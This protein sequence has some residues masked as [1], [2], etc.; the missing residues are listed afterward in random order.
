M[1]VS[2]AIPYMCVVTVAHS[3]A[4]SP[5]DE[6]LYV[7]ALL[8]LPTQGIVHEGEL[9]GDETLRM[10]SCYGVSPFGTFG[11]PCGS[12][13]SHRDYPNQGL[14]TAANNVPIYFAIT[15]GLGDALHLVSGVDY[16]TAWRLTGSAWLIGALMVLYGLIRSWRLSHLSVLA[17]GLAF[18]ASPFSWWT[19]SY[20]ST[21]APAF[22]FGALLLWL[23][24]RARTSSGSRW[25]LFSLSIVAI[26]FKITNVIGVVFALLYTLIDSVVHLRQGDSIISRARDRR[27]GLQALA[28]PAFGLAV[29]ITLQAAW[30]VVVQLWAVGSD[31]ADQ[32]ISIPLSGNEFLLQFTNFLPGTITSSPIGAYVPTFAY[33]PLSWLT[34]AGVITALF[35]IRR[36]DPHRSITLAI[37]VA[38]ICAAPGLAL[39]L[40]VLNGSYF[41]LPPRYGATLLPGFL[42]AT[43]FV[44]KSRSAAFAVVSYA[45]ALLI[46]GIWLSYYLT[47]LG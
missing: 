22:M 32:G 41:Q 28:A 5:I 46:V 21:D 12:Q 47:S 20:I 34:V 14:S 26:I 35:A 4:L 44:L 43:A 10:M 29:G 18:V 27:A 23:A 33:A 7:D 42:L 9:V 24:S 1:L 2:I 19:Y 31:R 30:L 6:W 37:A 39:A 25:W 11:S 16:L 3:R 8:K 38:S 40:Q 17:V 13:P 36:R 15:R 45:A